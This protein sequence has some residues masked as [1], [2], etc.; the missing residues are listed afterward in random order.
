[1][2]VKR[3]ICSSQLTEIS[4]YQS[5]FY[6]VE[7]QIMVDNANTEIWTLDDGKKVT[8]RHMAHSDAIIEHSCPK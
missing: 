4:C 8:L 7:D 5:F 2:P 1:M 3:R 6:G